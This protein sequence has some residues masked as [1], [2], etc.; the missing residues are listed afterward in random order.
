[1]KSQRPRVLLLLAVLL[2]SLLVLAPLPFVT[3]QGRDLHDESGS[4]SPKPLPSQ[5]VVRRAISRVLDAVV[6][7]FSG[8]WR[9]A[10]S[11]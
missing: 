2:L 3:V 10:P 5:T 4:D 1:M 9:I 7:W 6:Y 11:Q 8:E